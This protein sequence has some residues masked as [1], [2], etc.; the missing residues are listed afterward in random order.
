MV[1]VPKTAWE[2]LPL[3]LANHISMT[4]K[5]GVPSEPDVIVIG[6]TRAWKLEGCG[7]WFAGRV[8]QEPKWGR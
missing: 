8:G 6:E 3:P 4:Y 1:F 2:D 5:V 7:N